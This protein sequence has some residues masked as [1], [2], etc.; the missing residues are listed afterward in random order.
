MPL[1]IFDNSFATNARLSIYSISGEVVKVIDLQNLSLGMNKINLDLKD[2]SGGMYNA[3]IT[4]GVE[5]I[6]TKLIVVK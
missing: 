3:V 4:N 6:S 2:L 1:L 5:S